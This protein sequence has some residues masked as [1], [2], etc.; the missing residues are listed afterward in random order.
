MPFRWLAASE[1]RYANAHFSASTNGRLVYRTADANSV[2][3][4]WFDRQGRPVAEVGEPVSPSALWVSPDGR[5][6][7]TEISFLHTG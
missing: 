5:R 6:V 1:P 3:L 2:Q 4:T 7:A